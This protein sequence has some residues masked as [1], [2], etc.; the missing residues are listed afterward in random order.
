MRRLSCFIFVVLLFAS[1]ALAQKPSEADA[2]K[3]APADYSKEGYVVEKMDTS[4]HFE[5]DGTGRRE[6]YVRVKVQSEAGVREF[7]QLVFGYNS[8]NEQVEIP[9]V[10]VLKADGTTV[11][12]PADAVQ[13]LSPPITKEAP[14]Y[15]D[16]RQK[17]ITVPGL[18]PGEV[19]EYDMVAVMHTP[20]APNQ[21]WMEHDFS[22]FGII[23]N[24]QL[25]VNV[26]A[27]RKVTLKNKPEN[28]PKITE[29]SGRRIYRW[30]SSHL[31]TD[32]DEAK[33]DK[34]KDKKKKKKTKNDDMPAVQ[35]TTF[36]SWEEIGRWYAGLEKD[37]RQPTD[38]IRAKAASLTAG[39][40]TDI[41]KVESLYDYVARNF[42]YVSLSFGTGR[43]QPHAASEVLHNQ[44]GDCKDKHTLLA[45]LL[46]AEGM[47]ASSVL[48]NSSRKLDPDVPS[49][50]QFDH[51]I[52]MLPLG[53]E[54]V[55][56]DTTTEVAPFR[57][58]AFQLRKKQALVIPV[59]GTPHL[60]ETPADPPTPDTEVQEIEGKVSP[61][62]KLEAKVKV[63]GTGDTELGLRMVFRRVPNAQWKRVAEMFSAA[64]GIAGDV[65]DMGPI[66]PADTHIPFEL[67]Y[68][69]TDEDFLDWTKKQL[70]VDLPL[71]RSD[72]PEADDDDSPDADPI[73]LGPPGEH[74]YKIRL[75]LPKIYTAQIPVSFSIKRPYGEYQAT[76]HLEGQV[77]TA[78]RRLVMRESEL[79]A[80]S[81]RNYMAFRNAVAADIGQDLALERTTAGN[82]IP[83]D[84]K[85]E[86]LNEAGRKALSSGDLT[87]AVDLLERAVKA[88]AKQK[89]AW[90]NLGLAY[91]GLGQTDKAIPAFQKQIEMDPY[92][93]YAYNN[94]GRAYRILHK[95]PEA[96]D[97]F[98]KQIEVNPLDKY[99][100]ENL[101]D[102][103][104]DWKKYSDA[105]P[106]LEKAVTLN[107][108]DAELRIQLGTAYLNL[109]QDA[110]AQTAYEKA[111]DL[112]ATPLVW[113][114]IAYQ[115][116]LKGAKLDLAQ[117]YAESA[118]ASTAASS[119]NLILEQATMRDVGV[120][121]SL[122]A[123]WDT[124]GWIYFDKGE[125]DKAT[126][127]I[128]AAWLLSG[129]GEVGDHLGQVYEKAGKK[130]LAIQIYAQAVSSLFPIPESREKLTV[131]VGAKQV[132]SVLERN[133]EVLQQVRT[134]HLG[135][136]AKLTGSAD[137]LLAIGPNGAESAKF[138]SGEEKLKGMSDVLLK[139]KYVAPFPDDT[140][141][142]LLRRGTLACSTT[143]GNCDFVLLFPDDVHSLD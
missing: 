27:D 97:A 19:L 70:T 29:E 130:D 118:I 83:P 128:D 32:E 91:L 81:A 84:M 56:M 10:R 113:N 66:D 17:H 50:S 71:S 115:L 38:E 57:L 43:Y 78:E 26:P 65:D 114:N 52:T 104:L 125:L 48:I 40:T 135:K 1:P 23:L 9:F 99:A 74:I 110:K 62:G 47:H 63:S 103:Y 140:P 64:G 131:L 93:E 121:L 94:L 82:E 46:D 88:D 6:L 126:K 73:Q 133:R 22:K 111:V 24:E 55:W 33:K 109:G 42:R 98:H 134:V 18:R 77:F 123:Y 14:V 127:Y 51:V 16:Y 45:S 58:L 53:K 112:S 4:Y 76:Y 36:S 67:S 49:P 117:Q 7:G 12:A 108:E 129:R 34:D 143:T 69:I 139:A 25:E 61:A 86:D 90:N 31:E 60:E 41:D 54:E 21:F 96:E 132:D 5:N 68:K 141:A 119:R 89:Y 13:D 136:I 137:F 79:P 100:H 44:Y 39:K 106:E 59:S 95:Y 116:S 87:M 138:V 2:S 122:S 142:K 120:T 30:T 37:R 124:L 92:D 11:N 8:V 75:E 72:L 28:A 85:P 107:P 105:V 35:M 80:N 3:A 102:L 20:L 101:G 15:T